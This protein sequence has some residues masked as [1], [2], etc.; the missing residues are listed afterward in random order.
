MGV[1]ARPRTAAVLEAMVAQG[2]GMKLALNAHSAHLLPTFDR[3]HR[4]PTVRIAVDEQH[5]GRIQVKGELRCQHVRVLVS[6][7]NIELIEAV[8]EGISGINPYS[9]LN[10]ARNFPV[11]IVNWP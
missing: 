3:I 1:G 9:P 2:E 10:I 8:A 5:W 4:S 6:S 7:M 11:D